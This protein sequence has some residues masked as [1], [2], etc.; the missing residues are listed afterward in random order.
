MA[1]YDV[2][3]IGLTSPPSLAVL[4]SYRPAVSIRNNGIH[5]ALASGILRIYSAGLQVFATELYSAVIAPGA[6]GSALAV[7]YWTPTEG[8]YLVIADV[9][10]PLDQV[11][12]NNHLAP[13]KIVVSGAAP[14]PPPAVPYHAAQHE[15]GAADELIVDGLHGRLADSQTPLAHKAAHQAGGSDALDVTGLPGI[16]QDGQP[17]ADH[18]E[19]HEDHGDD[20]L[21][22]EGLAGVLFNKQKPQTHDNAA[23]D[24]NYTS[25]TDF[26]N[27]LNDTTKVHEVATNLEQV[28]NKEQADGYPGLD[29]NTRIARARLGQVPMNPTDDM[30]PRYD[31]DWGIGIVGE[32]GSD[33]HDETVA[34]RTGIDKLVPSGQLGLIG[35]V[36]PPAEYV[37]RA[38]QTWGPGGAAVPHAATHQDGGDD[39]I[40][41][42]GLSGVAHDPQTPAAHKSSHQDGGADEISIANLSGKAADAQTPTS[43]AFSHS[44]T[45]P[46]EININDLYG[47]PYNAGKAN[48][49]APLGADSLVPPEFLPA[50]GATA[51][52][53]YTRLAL[54]SLQV[55]DQ[56]GDTLVLGA[57]NTGTLIQPNHCLHIIIT[58]YVD[59]HA[60]DTFMQLLGKM[61]QGLIDTWLCSSTCSFPPS[62]VNG[63][64]FKY[65]ARLYFRLS[66]VTSFVELCNTATQSRS[67]DNGSAWDK[68]VSTSWQWYAHLGA[69]LL[70]AH[71]F[72]RQ[73]ILEP[74]T[75]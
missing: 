68:D 32:H 66:S 54:H 16:L 31:G 7:D 53:V 6:T 57:L 67:G 15:E 23:H 74:Y 59:P 13:T 29:E 5:E 8:T 47:Q 75:A 24:P 30:V 73:A 18:H 50:G 63:Q 55:V 4:Q 33:K 3:V 49:L 1:D 56:P 22:V 35:V 51:N 40:S 38:D 61:G 21:N 20:E 42:A 25:V 72:S 62:P 34:S 36:P 39:E 58:G 48:G 26:N 14:P 10:C 60:E 28:A 2:G 27:H 41:I 52:A 17:I 45:Q 64:F 43:H 12:L 44:H 65:D 71:I 69:P 9:T 19:S 46:D 70:S 37:L 11:E